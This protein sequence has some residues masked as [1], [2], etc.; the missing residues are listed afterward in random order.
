MT[1]FAATMQT[2]TAGRNAMPQFRGALTPDQ[3][4]DVSAY[5]IELA[6]AP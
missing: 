4:R 3:I 2:V 1:D 5:V 6:K